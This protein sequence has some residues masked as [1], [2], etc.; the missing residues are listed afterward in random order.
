M[1]GQSVVIPS[2]WGE[3][4]FEMVTVRLAKFLALLTLV[5]VG[6]LY[7][8]ARMIWGAEMM[9]NRADPADAR[10]VLTSTVES[11]K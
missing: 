4:L 10:L 3:R 6:V 1:A 9:L 8:P 11:R 2:S 5:G 7:S